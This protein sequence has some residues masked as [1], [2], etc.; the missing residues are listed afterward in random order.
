MD[1]RKALARKPTSLSLNNANLASFP[2]ELFDATQLVELEAFRAISYKGNPAM[3]AAIGRLKK[4]RSLTIGGNA[5]AT[6]PDAIGDLGVLENLAL[7]YCQSLESLPKTIGKLRALRSLSA[8]Y[9]TAL[10]SLPEEIGTLSALESIAL[11]NGAL[12]KVPA[13][14]WKLRSLKVL[15]LPEEVTTLPAGI[16]R[17][18]NLEDLHLGP[19]ALASIAKEIP[20][21]KKLK[22]LSV[23]GRIKALPEEVG[24]LR[25]LETLRICHLGLDK[26]PSRI[27]NLKA[28]TSLDVAG[29]KLKTLAALVRGL[30]ELREL[31]FG[32]NP[33]ETGEKREIERLMRLP[34]SKRAARAPKADSQ[35][36]QRKASSK[37]ER[38]GRAAST[39]AWLPL[40]L[41]D[42]DHARE[43]GGAGDG[44]EDESS[45]WARASSAV[46]SAEKTRGVAAAVDVGDGK[47]VVVVLAV[48]QGIATFFRVGERVT[49]CETFCDDERDTLFLEWIA[50]EPDPKAKHCGKVDIESGRGMA[51]ATMFAGE[52]EEALDFDL[53]AGTYAV[54]VEEKV[55]LSWGRGRRGHLIPA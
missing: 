3:P 35:K 48:G 4:L 49:F 6:L 26:L 40:L 55:D 28:L 41:A 27:A 20:K 29:N 38:I 11:T 8:S 15:A 45:D 1:L 2:S 54:L 21:L 7:D 16:A 51:L 31:S 24:E 12:K 13:A 39:N 52:E 43:W 17:L 34:P 50:S 9:T 5:F 19:K 22:R 10:E 46:A 14:L 47:G 36:K 42:A 53:T 33:L 44:E 32:D 30:P 37:P 23:W 25:A 18:E